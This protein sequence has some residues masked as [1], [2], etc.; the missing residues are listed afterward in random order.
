VPVI[1]WTTDLELVITST[2]GGGQARIGTGP[3]SNVGMSVAEVLG[4]EPGSAPI[5]AHEQALAGTAAVYEVELAGRTFESHVAPLRAPDGD[6]LGALGLALDVTERRAVEQ[7]LKEIE[8]RYQQLIERIPAVIYVDSLEGADTSVYVSP[9]I[10]DILGYSAEEWLSDPDLW[11][12]ILHPEDRAREVAASVLH[13]LTGEPY[14]A[15]YRIFSRDGQMKW[16]HD[17]GLVMRDDRGRPLFCHGIM[18]DIT[19]RKLAEQ[20]VEEALER[21]R[22]AAVQLRELDEMK[23]TFL[24][25][26]SHE[27]RTPLTT[28]LGAALT[29][30]RDDAS[31]STPDARDLI[32]RLASN[33]RKLD[34]LLTDLLDLDRLSR[35]IVEPKRHPVD[36]GMLVRT[37]VAESEQLAGRS[38]TVDAPSVTV[39]VDRPKVE[40][41]VEN[42]VANMARHTAPDVP[43]WV[44]VRGK[45]G[46]VLIS[47]EDSGPGVPPEFRNLIFEPFQ[48]GPGTEPRPGVGI[49]LSLVARFA[50]LHGGRAWV[51]ERPGGGS[52]FKVFLPGEEQGQPST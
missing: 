40:R 15:D 51:E 5:R 12:Q 28:I 41:I 34:H 25:A 33:A 36:V 29:L 52:S 18:I 14:R 44:R 1:V 35:G 48:Q 9:Q 24:S 19:E 42:L 11:E 23:N 26:V 17:E 8:F 10:V 4:V 6:V 30:D 31:I 38:V 13:H 20:A 22:E 2:G 3:N 45:E 39:P 50:E 16:L 47:V 46:G 7:R 37:I 32:R 27:L 21:Q 49:G 43:V